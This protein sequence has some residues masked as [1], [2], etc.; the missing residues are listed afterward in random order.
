MATKKNK[1]H[2][3]GKPKSFAAKRTMNPTSGEG[4]PPDQ[5]VPPADAFEQQDP[6]RRLGNFQTK[7]EHARTGRRGE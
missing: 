5:N 4:L 7:G 6:K 3:T 1:S 2:G